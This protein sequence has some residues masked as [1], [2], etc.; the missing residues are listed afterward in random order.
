MSTI[1]TLIVFGPFLALV[2]GMIIAFGIVA[3]R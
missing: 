2:G 1:D 3:I